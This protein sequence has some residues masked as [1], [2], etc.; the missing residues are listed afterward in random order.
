MSVSLITSGK[1]VQ[2]HDIPK[3]R[4]EET[5]TGTTCSVKRHCCDSCIEICTHLLYITEESDDEIKYTNKQKIQDDLAVVIII[6]KIITKNKGFT[7][8]EF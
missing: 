7:L 3:S 2:N 4:R 5:F 8:L 1:S 6:I